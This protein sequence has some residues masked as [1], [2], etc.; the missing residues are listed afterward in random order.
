MAML[1]TPSRIW[2]RI[3][4]TEGHDMPS[5]PSL[6]AF[7]DSGIDPSLSHSS[8]QDSDPDISAPYH[9]TPTASSSNTA[10]APPSVSST[11]RFAQ[12]IASRGGRSMSSNSA[13]I[14]V[15]NSMRRS[16]RSQD[17]LESFDDISMIPSLPQVDPEVG[18]DFDDS[19][20][21]LG[22]M[23]G[24]RG[25]I[26]RIDHGAQDDDEGLSLADALRSV[27]RTSSPFPPNESE[28]EH[29]Q[30]HEYSVSLK[31]EPKVRAV[32]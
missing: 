1:E 29:T 15:A 32:S 30:K 6:P 2:R 26:V 23:E 16:G 3:E 31:S 24:H 19:D 4:A 11:A 25:N 28:A 27:S 10:R 8:D 18:S 22:S 21:E 5:L 20:M 14:S 7:E 12:S 9:S 17:Q 13:H